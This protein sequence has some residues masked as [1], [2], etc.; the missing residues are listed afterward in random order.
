MQSIIDQRHSQLGHFCCQLEYPGRYTNRTKGQRDGQLLFPDHYEKRS[1]GNRRFQCI[2]HQRKGQ[3]GRKM[4]ELFEYRHRRNLYSCGCGC[5]F[6]PWRGSLRHL[7]IQQQ[8]LWNNFFYIDCWT[9]FEEQIVWVRFDK[10]VD[11]QFFHFTFVFSN[12]KERRLLVT[13]I[14]AVPHDK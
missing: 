8:N 3:K 14:R 7:Q 4:R 2:C 6:G 10:I 11:A 1:K 13:P 9:L 12:Q 5:H